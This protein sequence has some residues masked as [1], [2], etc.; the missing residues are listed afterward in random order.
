M[1][2]QKH[3]L[4]VDWIVLVKESIANIGIPSGFSCFDDFLR[5]ESCSGFLVYAIQPTVHYL[6]VSGEAVVF[7]IS[8][9]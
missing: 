1:P 4:L 3:R 2:S 8:D 7:G 9:M 6:V 5:L